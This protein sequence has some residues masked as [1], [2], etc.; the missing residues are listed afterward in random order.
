[1]GGKNAKIREW[2]EVPTIID[3]PF[4]AR[5][6]GRSYERTKRDCQAG[7][8]PAF[9]V[10]VEWRIQKDRLAEFIENGGNR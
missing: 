8:L 6:L 2:A 7:R 10:G 1:M 9:K 5:L 4:A 3:L